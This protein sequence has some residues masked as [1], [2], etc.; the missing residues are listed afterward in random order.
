MKSNLETV[1]RTVLYLAV[2]VLLNI[3][4][5]SL[6]FRIDL[7]RNKS[8]T[9]SDASKNAVATLQEPLTIKVFFSKNLPVPYNN[10]EQQVRD[11][12]EE[13]AH[14]G[15]EFFNY[16]FYS[17]STA[18]GSDPKQLSESE[19]MARR[20]SIVPIQIEKVEKD[21]VK[22]IRAYM[23][24]AF[25]HGDLLETIPAVTSADRLEFRITQTIRSLNERVSSLVN[26]Q[27]NIQVKL[28]LSSS[29]YD[30]VENTSGFP[31]EV[32]RIVDRLNKV[33][34]NRL[35]F[36]HLDPAVDPTL[37]TEAARY[38]IPP[39]LLGE[40]PAF[41]G[42]IITHGEEAFGASLIQGD[43]SGYQVATAESMSALIED[44]TKAILG[45]HEEIGY[46]AGFGTP[47]YRGSSGQSDAVETDLRTFYALVSKSYTIKGL[48]LE[49][50]E[51]PGSLKSLLIVSPRERLSDWALFQ[52]DQFLM[53]GG[54]V[55]LF[56]DPFDV[57]IGR[58]PGSGTLSGLPFY[59]PRETGLERMIENY[60]VAL[61]PSYVLDEN[62]F[63]SR[64]KNQQGGI[65]EVPVYFAPVIG[66][67]SFNQELDYLK[68]LN[69][70]ITIS[71]AP[72]K[73]SRAGDDRLQAHLLFSSS[74]QS[75]DLDYQDILRV[76]PINAQP[77]R[78][79]KKSYPLAYLLEGPFN[80]YF[81]GKPI[82]A[83]PEI[84][85]RTGEGNRDT[86]LSDSMTV[87]EKFLPQGHG[88]LFVMGGST[89]LEA[90]LLDPEGRRANSLF[91]LN[92]LDVMN[93]REERAVM[94]VKRGGI[95]PIEETTFRR[96]TFVKAFNIAV[97]PALVAA[98]GALVW[99]YRTGR[100]RR[101]QRRFQSRTA[102]AGRHRPLS[103]STRS[104]P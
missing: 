6:Y 21:E 85:G 70:L 55:I 81:A 19:E 72:L 64:D 12:L 26:L 31:A 73:L 101:I 90:S 18:E 95:S 42:I 66:K 44:S 86:I 51:I 94:R 96:R 7:T 104:E 14:W 88:K 16:R 52:I 9:L 32:E 62:C 57:F 92:I 89:V 36:S 100:K 103:Q 91:L 56:L 40:Q 8:Y 54:S 69:G 97:L 67:E 71:T 23:G 35:R 82:P 98:A 28:F 11:L 68:N 15:N 24:L 61:S 22:L 83:R 84:I 59:S 58:Q 3:A 1:L 5:T 41:A 53:R 76:N 75:W 87:E 38:R 27:E 47:P 99:L 13:Y 60:G 43:A 4:A 29:L 25:Q 48:L 65:D 74:D 33:Y 49:Q 79:G 45:I 20:N 30:F 2:V 34:F 39:L 78:S 37:I 80:S 50:R 93:D 46:L 102:T 77:P 63:I 17:M 10:I